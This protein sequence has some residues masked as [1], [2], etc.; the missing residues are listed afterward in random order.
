M[1]APKQDILRTLALLLLLLTTLPGCGLVRAGV[2][3]LRSTDGFKPIESDKRVLAEPGA[4]ELARQV[5]GYLS[6]AIAIVEREQFRDFTK[7]VQVYVCASEESFV[8]ST[9]ASKNAS[10]VV[11]T[12]LFFSKRLAGFPPDQIRARVIHEL[13]HLH[14]EQQLGAYGFD[15]H[16]PAWFQEGLAVVVSQGGGA[17]QVS[18][19]EAVRALLKGSR[20]VPE[21]KGSFFFKKSAKSYGLEPH[22]FYK[23]ASLFVEYLKNLSVMQ[24]GLFLLALEDGRDFE[25]SFRSVYGMAIDEAWGDFLSRL[26]EKEK[27]MHFVS[28]L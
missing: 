20:F 16:I 7:P 28:A 14:L 19:G 6:E 17:E 2:A 9:G 1:T 3:A 18:D 21:S 12:K 23:Q 22:L 5:A 26:K 15:T 10:G 25:K 8:R 24:F 27:E 13:S 11:T 4:E